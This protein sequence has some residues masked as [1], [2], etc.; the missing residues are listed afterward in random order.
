M[1]KYSGKLATC[2][3]FIFNNKTEKIWMQTAD[4]TL[5]SDSMPFGTAS[6]HVITRCT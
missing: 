1:N 5:N 6:Q 4:S 3:N 2:V